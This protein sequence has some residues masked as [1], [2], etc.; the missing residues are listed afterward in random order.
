MPSRSGNIITRLRSAGLSLRVLSDLLGLEGP[1]SAGSAIRCVY[2][3]RHNNGDANPSLV[4]WKNGEGAKC[5]A[6]GFGGGLLDIAADRLR[7]P[8]RK[9][10]AAAL[11]ARYLPDDPK[12][13][14]KADLGSPLATYDYVDEEGRLL[15]QTLRYA[16]RDA[17]GHPAKTFRVRRPHKE[18]PGSWIWKLG[19]TRIVPYQLPAVLQAIAN[20]DTV[21]VAEGEKD[22]DALTSAGVVATTNHGGSNKWRP[23][24]TEALRGAKQ[25]IVIADDDP[26]GR[27]HALS[28]AAALTPVVASVNI[29]LPAAGKDA[30]DH[31]AAGH[32]L[33]DFAEFVPEEHAREEHRDRVSRPT[34]EIRPDV[35]DVVDEAEQAILNSGVELYQRLGSLVRVMRD[36]GRQL[37]A[38][39]RPARAPTLQVLPTDSLFEEASRAAVWIVV[40]EK[41]TR[42]VLPPKWAIKV[43]EARGRWRFPYLEAVVEAP[44]LRVDGTILDLPGYDELTGLLYEP[45]AEYPPVPD[46]PDEDT[47]QAALGAL[48]APFAEFCFIS[49]ADRAATLAVLLTLVARHTIYGPTP[50]FAVLAPTPGSGKGLLVHAAVLLATG[51]YPCLMAAEHDNEELRKVIT[52]VAMEGQSAVLF[53]NAEGKFGSSVLAGALTAT[54]WSGRILG[55]SRTVT[56]PLCLTWFVTGNNVSFVGDTFRRVLPVRLDPQVE[57]PED[58]EFRHPDLLHYIGKERPRLLVCALTLLRAFYL[59]GR[60][61]HGGSRLGSFEAWDDLVRSAVVWLLGV[62]PCETR[63]RL[64]EHDDADK[65]ALRAAL[66]AWAS[67]FPNGKAVTARDALRVAKENPGGMLHEALVGVSD[68]GKLPAS[69]ALGYALRRWRWTRGGRLRFDQSDRTRQGSLWR[70]VPAAGGKPQRRGECADGADGAD[71][72]GRSENRNT[73]RA[74]GAGSDGRNPIDPEHLHDLHHQHTNPAGSPRL[75]RP[76]PRGGPRRCPGPD[77][78]SP[79]RFARG[80]GGVSCVGAQSSPLAAEGRPLDPADG[81]PLP[82]LPPD[83]ATA[84]EEPASMS[85][86]VTVTMEFD[87]GRVCHCCLGD[88]WREVESEVE[89]WALGDSEL[90][91]PPPSAGKYSLAVETTSRD[92]AQNLVAV[93]GRGFTG[94]V[95]GE[96]IHAPLRVRLRRESCTVYYDAP[97]CVPAGSPT[98]W[99]RRRTISRRK[100]P[101][102]RGNRVVLKAQGTVPPARL[103]RMLRDLATQLEQEGRV[104]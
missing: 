49:E 11:A 62:D 71:V 54:E 4:I 70:V 41:G 83:P 97:E 99:K 100:D 25:V 13:S 21:Y 67:T 59:A 44:V 66:S 96:R 51:R 104:P 98:Y 37:K 80:G 35:A 34:I 45:N 50:L 10:A 8:D 19:K 7:L 2:P 69:A 88:L 31:L 36:G 87:Q 103:A 22:V 93:L 24:H 1:P 82:T 29:V 12:K 23:A 3:D 92:V 77:G 43:L 38:L 56:A 72:S 78:V 26:P 28:V 86:R 74:R 84:G 75:L 5:Q 46:R 102:L 39:Q 65:E 79:P 33:D 9:T 53:D 76:E 94:T 52:T 73:D 14:T 101:D 55:V 85:Y 17:A 48:L 18:R 32:G 16:T 42:V 81:G 27:R 95:E 30:A 57:R 63:E 47:V 58:R 40:T 89:R 61:P 60:P 90:V 91:V 20:G 64:R 15:F 68:H 6:C